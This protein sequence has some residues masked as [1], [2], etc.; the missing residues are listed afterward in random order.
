MTTRAGTATFAA[1]DLEAWAFGVVLNAVGSGNGDEPA[2]RAWH[3]M[4][5]IGVSLSHCSLLLLYQT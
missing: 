5:D 1:P 2:F 4:T 3:L